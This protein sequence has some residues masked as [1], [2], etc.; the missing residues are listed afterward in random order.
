MSNGYQHKPDS[1][2]SPD[3]SL[4]YCKNSDSY[5]SLRK[6]LGVAPNLTPEVRGYFFAPNTKRYERNISL[7]LVHAAF[8]I[9]V[10]VRERNQQVLERQ[11]TSLHHTLTLSTYLISFRIV[12]VAGVSH[13][14]QVPRKGKLMATSLPMHTV[15]T[16]S[17]VVELLRAF[18]LSL[19]IESC[20]QREARNT[21][22]AEQIDRIVSQCDH[23]VDMIEY[24]EK[25]K[26][27]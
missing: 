18:A 9:H 3:S 23:A 21:K 14:Q 12:I 20:E 24:E 13:Q 22:T 27:K 19:A 26:N 8:S 25:R 11:S 4:G 6:A 2:N 10:G 16:A 1:R 17:E 7:C 15:H 5:L